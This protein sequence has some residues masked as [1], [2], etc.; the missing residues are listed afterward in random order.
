MIKNYNEPIIPNGSFLWSEYAYLR[1]LKKFAIPTQ[2]Q[3]ENARFLFSQL[4]SLRLELGLPLIITSGARTTE[5]TNLLRSRGI[6][7]ARFSAHNSWQ[8]VDLV[9]PKLSVRE[10]YRFFDKRWLG[11]MELLEFTPTWVHLDTREWGR[12]I[13]FRP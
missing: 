8:G 3:L 5:Y 11:R 4:Q 2:Q 7:A 13:R 9:C 12:G 10:L 6:P 1:L